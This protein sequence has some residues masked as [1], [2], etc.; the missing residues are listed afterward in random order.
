VAVYPVVRRYT[1][2]LNRLQQDISTA[3]V[4][5]ENTRIQDLRAKNLHAILFSGLRRWKVPVFWWE[6]RRPICFPVMSPKT[7]RTKLGVRVPG[8]TQIGDATLVRLVH[9]SDW[10]DAVFKHNGTLSQRVP[11]LHTNWER[12]RRVWSLPLLKHDRGRLRF[13][14]TRRL[15]WQTWRASD[16]H[17]R[18]LGP[19]RLISTRRGSLSDDDYSSPIQDFPYLSW[20]SK[21]YYRDRKGSYPKP[22]ESN[23]HH[24]T[25]FKN[26]SIKH[27]LPHL[28]VFYSDLLQAGRPRGR[29]SSPGGGKNFHVSK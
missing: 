23:P 29:G 11:T 10:F 16:S 5:D 28:R 6:K 27:F 13:P 17:A 14:V 1:D 15:F 24:H 19:S 9:D 3:K 8:T 2:C 20:I 22:L 18:A 26:D 7:E 12:Q 21:V 4:A 25:L